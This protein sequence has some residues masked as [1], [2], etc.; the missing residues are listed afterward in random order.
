MESGGGAVPMSTAE[1]R[2]LPRGGEA[3]KGSGGGGGGSDAEKLT[4]GT[5]W[6]ESGRA[7]RERLGCELLGTRWV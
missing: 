3:E 5:R 2:E 6:G 7:E 4:K 1:L